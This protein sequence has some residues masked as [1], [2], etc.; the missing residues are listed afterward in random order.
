MQAVAERTK[1]DDLV[2]FKKLFDDVLKAWHTQNSSNP[3]PFYS[4]DPGLKFFDFA[5]LKFTGW[6]EYSEGVQKTFFDNMPPN[7]SE[8]KLLDDFQVKRSGNLAVTSATFHFWAKMKDG[9][10]LE[11]DGRVTSVWE[12]TGD[13]WLIVHDH[14]SFPL[15]PK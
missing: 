13:R 9:S 3:A 7:S 12:K 8:L 4:K 10:K 5:P 2:L 11:N 6:K 15:S 1:E 14:W